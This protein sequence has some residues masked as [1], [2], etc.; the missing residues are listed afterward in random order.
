MSSSIAN[1][2]DR[3]ASGDKREP[4]VIIRLFIRIFESD[5]N[6]NAPMGTRIIIALIASIVTTYVI[7]AISTS[8]ALEAVTRISDSVPPQFSAKG[9]GNSISSMRNGCSKAVGTN[10]TPTT[11]WNFTISPTTFPRNIT[12]LPRTP[13]RGMRCSVRC[14]AGLRPMKFLFL[15]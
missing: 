2:K 5:I 11:A 8:L 14:S 13:G 4:D 12:S 15:L 9:T 6:T 10:V 3:E 7:P 1:N